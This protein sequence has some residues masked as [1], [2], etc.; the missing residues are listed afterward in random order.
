MECMRLI[1][2]DS[3]STTG[4]LF[5]GVTANSAVYSWMVS[6]SGLSSG[7]IVVAFGGGVTARRVSERT[8]DEGRGGFI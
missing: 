5:F 1:E 6:G 3:I 7:R 8:R 4:F 2:G